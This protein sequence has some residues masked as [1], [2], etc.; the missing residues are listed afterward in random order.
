M[1]LNRK[2]SVKRDFDACFSW[3]WRALDGSDVSVESDGWR[4]GKPEVGG[5]RAEVG[6]AKVTRRSRAG[7][8]AERAKYGGN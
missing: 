2:R 7:T 3:F 8:N 4:G 6:R 1:K 5:Q